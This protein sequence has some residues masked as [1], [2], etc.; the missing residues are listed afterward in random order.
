MYLQSD[1]EEV[2]RRIKDDFMVHGNGV[3]VAERDG[4]SEW[5]RENPFGVRSDW[6]R[7]V[8][9]RGKPMFRVLLTKVA[10]T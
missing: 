4:D 6:E 2:A 5:I 7:H 1:I 10:M 9:A 8:L 3:L